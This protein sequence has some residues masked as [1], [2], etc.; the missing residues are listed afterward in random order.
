MLNMAFHK[1]FVVVGFLGGLETDAAGNFNTTLIGDTQ[2]CLAISQ[3]VVGVCVVGMSGSK[4]GECVK[5]IALLKD[6]TGGIKSPD[7]LRRC[8]ESLA[9]YN[10]SRY[11]EV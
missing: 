10:V 4:V 11:I 3:T 5:A 8:R 1:D 9:P 6:G 7:L 2:A